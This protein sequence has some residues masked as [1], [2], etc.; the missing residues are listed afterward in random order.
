VT[1]REVA[2]LTQWRTFTSV[3]WIERRTEKK[4]A[5]LSEDGFVILATLSEFHFNQFETALSN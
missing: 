3:C 5:L 4:E 1:I 2:E